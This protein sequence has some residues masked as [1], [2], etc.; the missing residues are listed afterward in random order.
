MQVM[1]LETPYVVTLPESWGGPGDSAPAT[2]FGVFQGM[3]A[4]LKAVYGNPNVQGRSV[5]VQGVGA[6]GKGVVKYLVEGGAKVLIADV[7]AESLRAISD[8]YAV[9]VISPQQVAQL[10]VDVYCPCAMGGTLSE[11]SIPELRCE[12]VCGSANNQLDRKSVV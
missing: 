1:R 4:C 8:Q 12:I 9:E 6:V 5:A 7:D 2:A 10:E 11:R 3:R